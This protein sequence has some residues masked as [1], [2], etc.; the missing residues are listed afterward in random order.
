MNPKGQH[1]SL[2]LL[3]FEGSLLKFGFFRQTYFWQIPKNK[4]YKISPSISSINTILLLVSSS[5]P[6]TWTAAAAA[7]A[8]M[9][10]KRQCLCELCPKVLQHKCKVD[11]YGYK[12]VYTYTY[13]RIHIY[14]QTHT[15]YW[16]FSI[17]WWRQRDRKREMRK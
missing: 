13:I 5:E 12:Y 14:S 1:K 7:A 2:S 9:C 16:L 17:H 3:D 4:S 8:L 15:L 10:E 6:S 11:T